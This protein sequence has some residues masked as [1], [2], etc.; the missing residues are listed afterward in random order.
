MLF[1][2]GEPPS[3]ELVEADDDDVDDAADDDAGDAD[4]DVATD[5]FSMLALG[6][7]GAEIGVEGGIAGVIGGTGVVDSGVT[8]MVEIWVRS[9]S[10]AAN[11]RPPKCAGDNPPTGP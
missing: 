10:S 9:R 5:G 1:S 8:T 6:A 2:V 11:L 3:N 7:S 4:G